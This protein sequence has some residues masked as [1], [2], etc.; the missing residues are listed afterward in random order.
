MWFLILPKQSLVPNL[1]PLMA[2]HFLE[3]SGHFFGNKV[4][5]VTDKEQ[6]LIQEGSPLSQ[7]EC[8]AGTAS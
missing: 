6:M 3:T 2:P 8:T 4:M 7:G 1:P 5:K